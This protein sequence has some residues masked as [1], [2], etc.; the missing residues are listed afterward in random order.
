MATGLSEGA[1]VVID[2]AAVDAQQ[3]PFD[4]ALALE[5]SPGATPVTAL[6]VDDAL[7]AIELAIVPVAALL[8]SADVSSSA[9]CV[10]RLTWSMGE[11]AAHL[12]HVTRGFGD[13]AWG[14]PR[15]EATLTFDQ[16]SSINW[17]GIRAIGTTDPVELAD[18]LEGATDRAVSGFRTLDGD[19][20]LP[21]VA[22]FSV[23]AATAAGMFLGELLVHGYDIAR[24][25]DK[26]YSIDPAH[27]RVVLAAATELAPHRVDRRNA[28]GLTATYGITVRGGE[29]YRFVFQRGMLAVKPWSSDARI[30]CHFSAEPVAMLLVGYGRIGWV[31]PTLRGDLR[32]WGRKP[33]L[34]RRYQRLLLRP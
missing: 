11:T 32:S 22:G 12:V 5:A 15:E 9:E 3:T 13:M 30:D 14:V 21:Y 19:R 25:L 7:D 1:D 26:P 18:E 16:I 24:V 10:P 29:Q 8:R 28:R 34:G 6:D 4:R 20:R 23:S 33:W 17:R 31:L 2:V 27:A